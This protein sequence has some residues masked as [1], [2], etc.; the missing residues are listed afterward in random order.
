ME[1]RWR[2][3]IFADFDPIG[4]PFHAVVNFTLGYDFCL[5][6]FICKGFLMLVNYGPI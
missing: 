2:T 1:L 3:L 6:S 5:N 4:T